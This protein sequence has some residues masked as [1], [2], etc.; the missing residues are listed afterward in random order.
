MTCLLALVLISHAQVAAGRADYRSGEFHLAAAHFQLA[1]DTEPQNAEAHYWLG[2]SYETLA[3]IA[4]PFGR[5]YRSLARTHLTKAAE[6]APA[7]SEYR[8]ELFE[9]LLDTGAERQ[10]R[11]MLLS[12]AESDPDYDFMLS[13]FTETRRLNSSFNGRL[14][15]MFQLATAWH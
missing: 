11:A 8:H 7:R 15:H 1:V 10:A 4:T 3:D 14:A 9:F 2:R 12:C 6:L 5:R 13:R